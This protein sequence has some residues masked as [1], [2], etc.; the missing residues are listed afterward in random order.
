[1]ENKNLASYSRLSSD[2]HDNYYYHSEK[3]YLLQPFVMNFSMS[4]GVRGTYVKTSL[5]LFHITTLSSIRTWSNVLE[6]EFE[7][8]KIKK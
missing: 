3:W 5:P 6:N 1:M 2:T 4:S 8:Q 7:L